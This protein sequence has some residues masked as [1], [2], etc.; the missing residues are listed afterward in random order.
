MSDEPG[1]AAEGSF[2]ERLA[3]LADLVGKLEGGQL[4]LSDSIDAYERGVTLVRAL[5]AELLDVEQRVRILTAA[6]AT[7][8]SAAVSGTDGQARDTAET[9]RRRGGSRGS[10]ASLRGTE[11]SKSPVP[12][13]GSPRGGD[14]RKLPGMDDTNA[15]A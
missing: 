1:G 9:V 13:S 15:E 12:P 8:G 14:S 6:P 11:S 2:E 7:D 5:H 4:G 3:R 10:K